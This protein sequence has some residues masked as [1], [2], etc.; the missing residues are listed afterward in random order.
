MTWPHQRTVP[1]LVFL[2]SPHLILF[3]I[4]QHF[5]LQFSELFV[6][7]VKLLVNYVYQ[8]IK[9]I[10][11]LLNQCCW[12]YLFLYYYTLLIVTTNTLR[13]ASTFKWRRSCQLINLWHALFHLFLYSFW[14][15]LWI[16][17]FF[18][19]RRLW[20][21]FLRFF[22]LTF[23]DPFLFYRIINC[24]CLFFREYHLICFG[25]ILLF[26]AK[27][28][29][30]NSKDSWRVFFSRRWFLFVLFLGRWWSGLLRSCSEYRFGDLLFRLFFFTERTC[31]YF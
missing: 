7:L 19:W 21:L 5:L 6:Q 24:F 25:F 20:N 2:P 28:F 18:F 14:R 4:S 8:R 29:A 13:L 22:F 27:N 1:Q 15:Y 9:R 12:N 11:R 23:E 26:I 30:K 10:V 31:W 16:N 17:S 3:F